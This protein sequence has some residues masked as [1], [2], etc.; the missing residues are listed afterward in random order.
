ML[1]P[2]TRRGSKLRTLSTGPHFAR[3]WSTK[4]IPGTDRFWRVDD[5]SWPGSTTLVEVTLD[6]SSTGA[7]IDL[8]WLPTAGLT[9]TL[10][11]T[12]LDTEFDKHPAINRQGE[13]LEGKRVSHAPEWSLSGSVLYEYDFSRVTAFGSLSAAYIGDHNTDPKLDKQTEVDAY[14]LVNGRVGVRTIDARWEVALWANN[15]FDEEYHMSLFDTPLQ[16]GSWSS[17]RGMPRL[18]GASIRY[19][20]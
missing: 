17:F 16:D 12:Y 20:Y 3:P 19:Q 18:Y 14:T 2:N 13:S 8:T 11:A 5:E 7:E 4:R 15:L 10:G 9:F 6:G 1:T